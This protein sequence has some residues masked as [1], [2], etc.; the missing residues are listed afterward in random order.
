VRSHIF[1]IINEFKVVYQLLE[2]VKSDF[3]VRTNVKH[4]Y[5]ILQSKYKIRIRYSSLVSDTRA[6]ILLYQ[7]GKCLRFV[8]LSDV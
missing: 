3:E 5:E 4:N 7:L 2:K 6:Y 1:K 8:P